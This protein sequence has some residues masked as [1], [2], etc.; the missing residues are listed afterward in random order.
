MFNGPNWIWG[1][2]R[3]IGQKRVRPECAT[4]CVAMFDR[5]SRGSASPTF[6][7]PQSLGIARCGTE[8][9]GLDRAFLVH[10]LRCRLEVLGTDERARCFWI[11]VIGVKPPL[12][13]SS[14]MGRRHPAVTTQRSVKLSID[15]PGSAADIPYE[16]GARRCLPLHFKADPQSSH[17][18]DFPEPFTFN[19][20]GT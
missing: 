16:L 2:A 19:A 12:D 10:W 11:F 20:S 9:F 18:F 7:G 15:T 5:V 3:L 14:C 1:R 13:D 4:R 6:P 8:Q 17:S